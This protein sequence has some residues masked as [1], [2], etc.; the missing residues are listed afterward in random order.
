MEE[1][2]SCTTSASPVFVVEAAAV[3]VEVDVV[4]GAPV[5]VASPPLWL[6]GGVGGAV[7]VSGLRVE[8]TQVKS[9]KMDRFMDLVE[10]SDRPLSTLALL[11]RLAESPSPRPVSAL[12]PGNT[13]SW[14]SDFS[15]S[16][17]GRLGCW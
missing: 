10:R 7:G 14:E 4:C 5:M 2:E 13:Q 12:A 8:E 3:V 11:R 16:G 9:E 17:L 1:V 6:G 15:S